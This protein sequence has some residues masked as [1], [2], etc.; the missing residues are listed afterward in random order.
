MTRKTGV[1]VNKVPPPELLKQVIKQFKRGKKY[2]RFKDNRLQIQL[3]WDHY[4]LRTGVKYLLSLIDIFTKNAWV[5]SLKDKTA[6]TVLD[7]FIEIVNMFKHKP[8][9]L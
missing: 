2:S 7:G 1:N 5:K 8:N 9:K 4:L 6:K 3:K